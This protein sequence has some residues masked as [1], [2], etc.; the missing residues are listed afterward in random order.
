MMRIGIML[1][2]SALFT[3]FV[4]VAADDIICFV[5]ECKHQT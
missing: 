1:L 3:Y 4:Y 5:K 2:I